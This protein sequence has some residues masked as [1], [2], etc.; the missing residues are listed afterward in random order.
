MAVLRAGGRW[1][2]NDNKNERVEV[3][4]A[5]RAMEF[6]GMEVEAA[7]DAGEDG[8]DGGDGGSP[9]LSMKVLLEM[10]TISIKSNMAM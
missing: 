9:S 5:P 4:E 1:D 8:I 6:A 2:I 10:D 7:D 3:E